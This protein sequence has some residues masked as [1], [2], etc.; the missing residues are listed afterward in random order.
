MLYF[1]FL[2]DLKEKFLQSE[3]RKENTQYTIKNSMYC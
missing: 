1:N 3:R 2:A